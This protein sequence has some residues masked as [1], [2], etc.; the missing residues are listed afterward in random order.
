MKS[1]VSYLT[2]TGAALSLAVA[3]H[4]LHAEDLI[5]DNASR[6]GGIANSCANSSQLLQVQKLSKSTEI[7]GIGPTG[8]R[9]RRTLPASSEKSLPFHASSKG[10]SRDPCGID[11][12]M[13]LPAPAKGCVASA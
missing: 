9:W 4:L 3:A 7:V 6:T 13:P 1:P 12:I 5:S 10:L 2:R 11:L 8:E